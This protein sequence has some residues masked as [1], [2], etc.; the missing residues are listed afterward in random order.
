MSRFDHEDHLSELNKNIG[1][2]SKLGIIHKTL[3]SDFPFISRIAATL[4]DEK[5]DMLKTFIH[6]SDEDQPLT[7]YQAKLSES[8]SLKNVR[9]QARSR[10]ID[11][12]CILKGNCRHTRHIR[13]Q[14]HQSSYTM[15]MIEGEMLVGF[16][17]FDARKK[18]AFSDDVLRHLDPYGHLIAMLIINELKAKN[19]LRA[20]VKTAQDIHFMRDDETGAH[21]DRMSRISRLI[22]NGLATKHGL[23]DEEVES[24]FIFSPLHDIGKLGIPDHIMFKKGELTYEEFM[25]MKTHTTLGRQLVDQLLDNFAL[26]AL[27]H[28]SILR[29]IAELHHET[30]DGNGYP[31]GHKQK[32]IPIEA[33][34][35]AVADIFD[36]LTSRRC[37]KRPWSNDEAFARLE[38]LSKVKLDPECVSTL[39]DHRH[40]VEAIQKQFR[41]RY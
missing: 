36:A 19:N 37:Y 29:N 15:P 10:V 16:L 32:D 13:T 41:E 34:I 11:D 17:F 30:L 26:D 25:I 8:S 39:I 27:P 33:R 3:N 9:E 7:H 6:S 18:N 21:L 4:Y 28:V 20:A 38:Q 12:L 40:E 1:L 14:G 5:T 35:V 31:F 24:I 2:S 23:S 22:A